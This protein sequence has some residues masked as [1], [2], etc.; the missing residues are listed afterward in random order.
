MVLDM[1]QLESC[2]TDRDDVPHLEQRGAGAANA[3]PGT[4]AAF[5]Y[6]EATDQS[7]RGEGN[8]RLATAIAQPCTCEAEAD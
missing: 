6:A 7:G 1:R 8:R 5:S 3:P 2:L 4:L